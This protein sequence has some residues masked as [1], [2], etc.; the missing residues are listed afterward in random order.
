M[1][2]MSRVASG[3]LVTESCNRDCIDLRQN[4][5]A[6]PWHGTSGQGR[7]TQTTIDADDH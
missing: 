2:A 1:T 6:L 7:T 4:P 3:D 5:A